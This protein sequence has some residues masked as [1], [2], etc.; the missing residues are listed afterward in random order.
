MDQHWVRWIIFAFMVCIV[1]ALMSGLYFIVYKRDRSA[2]AVK[3]LT[4]RIGLSLLL[5]IGLFIAFGMGWLTPH[6]L[7]IAN[8]QTQ[9]KTTIPHPQNANTMPPL[10]NQNGVQD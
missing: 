2:R 3:A 10:Q 1:W 5:F 6:E 8:T 9:T 7:F 4:F